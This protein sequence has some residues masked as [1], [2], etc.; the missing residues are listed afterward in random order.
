MKVLNEAKLRSA[1]E[2]RMAD[3]IAQNRVGGASLLV[4]QD[5][6]EIYRA[7]FTN[8]QMAGQSVTEDTLYRLASMTKPISGVA[9]MILVERG[10]LRL[11]DTV[12]SYLGTFGDMLVLDGEGGTFPT[13]RRVTVRHLLTHTSGIGSGAAIDYSTSHRTS[14][15]LVDN[16]S[17]VRHLEQMPLSFVPGT[18]QE[19]SGIAAFS[20]LTAIIQKLS[21]LSYEEFLQKEI[22]RPLGMVDTTFVPSEAQRA[23]IIPMHDLVEGECALGPTYEG[24]VFEQI[25]V[26][27]FLGGA[28]LVS[29][30]ADYARF[31]TMLLHGGAYEG[32]RILTEE[33]VRELSR[34]DVPMSDTESWGLGVRAVRA[35]GNTLPIGAF[36]W[37]GAYGTHFFVEPEN[38]IV[39]IYMKNSAY[40]GGSGAVTSAN[41]ERDVYAALGE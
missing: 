6:K 8:P 41:F 9:A 7:S 29:S 31:A 16:A 11:D 14:A 18:R 4:V 20:V 33:S 21:G 39:G 35:Q 3:D 23:R 34:P 26:T 30:T 37:S 13:D 32:G 15:D 2:K 1:I 27:N 38:R 19:Y 25:P 5:G 36:G 10:L 40:D 12:E 22:F 24:C 17:Y 28:G